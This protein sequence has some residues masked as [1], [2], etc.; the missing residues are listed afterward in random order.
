MQL[1][2]RF[3]GVWTVGLRQAKKESYSTLQGLCMDTG[4]VELRQLRE[5]GVI[6]YSVILGFKSL[7]NGL[8]DLRS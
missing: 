4:F 3:L 8:V 1:L 2:S 5:V 6:S 7:V